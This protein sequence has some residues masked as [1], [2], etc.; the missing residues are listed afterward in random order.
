M[1]YI[2]VSKLVKKPPRKV[3]WTSLIALLL[4]I[5]I[6]GSLVSQYSFNIIKQRHKRGSTRIGNWTVITTTEAGSHSPLLFDSY[7][8]TFV[9]DNAANISVCKDSRIFIGPL[10]DS[11]VT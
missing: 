2:C 11:N 6:Y 5:I 4:C 7:G 10:N 9:V 3:S 1:T 8:R